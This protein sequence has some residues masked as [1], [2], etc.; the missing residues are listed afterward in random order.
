MSYDLRDLP[1]YHDAFYEGEKSPSKAKPFAGGLG[2]ADAFDDDP[3]SG[4]A[5]VE[6]D[7]DMADMERPVRYTKYYRNIDKRR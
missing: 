7:V 5:K 1:K 2:P 6:D 3:E 4:G